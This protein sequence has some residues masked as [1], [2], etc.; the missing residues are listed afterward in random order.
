[1]PG[2][3]FAQWLRFGAVAL[4]SI[5]LASCGGGSGESPVNVPDEEAA[6]AEMRLVFADYFG[7]ESSTNS[8]TIAKAPLQPGNWV[9]DTGYGDEG[10]GN[11]EWQLYTNSIDNLFTENGHLVIKADCLTPPACGKRDGTITSAKVTSKDRVNVKFG[12]IKARIRMPSGAGMWPAFWT[13]GADIDERPWPDAGEIDIVEMHYYYSDT[14]TT[15]FSTHWAGP[16]YTDDNRP[17]CASNTSAID[18]TEE[19]NCTTKSKTFKAEDGYAPLTDD[20][21]VYEVEWTDKA[22]IGKIDGITYFTQSIDGATMEEFLKDHYLILNV[23][24]G[25]TLGGPGGPTMTAA[26]WLD[27]N[28]TDM[29]VDWVEVWER[30]PPTGATLWDNEFFSDLTYNRIINTAEFNGG[31]VKANPKSTAV[32]PLKG[33]QVLELTYSPLSRI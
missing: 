29:R 16:R 7:D 2:K 3:S 17:V 4:F 31:F 28:Q 8:K 24:V 22:I 12:K 21:H 25:G 11:D 20:F 15:H 23:A 1:M 9:V 33:T 14:R 18:S 26:D 19:E 10:W 27:P 5:V 13:L 30:V 32:A 6:S